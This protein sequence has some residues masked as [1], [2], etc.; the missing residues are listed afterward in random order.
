MLSLLLTNL[1]YI[2]QL[3]FHEEEKKTK[4]LGSVL[5]TNLNY[6]LI[7]DLLGS[8]SEERNASPEIF[9]FAGFPPSCPRAW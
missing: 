3:A 2:S 4:E 6:P 8:P 5:K 1:F 7:G 9:C